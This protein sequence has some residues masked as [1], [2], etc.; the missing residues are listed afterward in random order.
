M[1]GTSPDG[2]YKGLAS[3]HMFGHD[4][5]GGYRVGISSHPTGCS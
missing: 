1:L 5:L 3:S 2:V 4:V